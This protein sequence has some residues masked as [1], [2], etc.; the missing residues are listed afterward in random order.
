MAQIDLALAASGES[1][2]PMWGI[3]RLGTL[4]AGLGLGVLAYWYFARKRGS[5]VEVHARTSPQQLF[6]ELC[7]A[8]GLSAAQERL[9]EW[10]AS[11]RQ[12][13][14][15]GLLFVDP[16]HLERAQSRSDNPG[17]RK[18]LTDLRTKLFAGL[19]GP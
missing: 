15:P 8:H 18:R 19:A 13:A 14:M 1:G 16:L 9:L 3:V 17:V 7:Q 4:A 6:H 11:D 2:A 12:L 5:K 10:V